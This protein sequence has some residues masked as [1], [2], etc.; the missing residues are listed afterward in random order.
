MQSET[1]HIVRKGTAL[2]MKRPNRNARPHSGWLTANFG[3]TC[4]RRPLVRDT[5]DGGGNLLM[6]TPAAVAVARVSALLAG[7]I[8]KFGRP[9]KGEPTTHSLEVLKDF[10]AAAKSKR[11]RKRE[12]RLDYLEHEKG[13]RGAK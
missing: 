5:G 1:K 3:A 4:L 9:T 2:M 8:I 12:T 10:D 13:P 11:R 7:D 6:D